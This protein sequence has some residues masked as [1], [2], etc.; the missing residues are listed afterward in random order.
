VSPEYDRQ[1]CQV[2]TIRL[3]ARLEAR[4][5]SS[6]LDLVTSLMSTSVVQSPGQK[7]ETVV[8]RLYS[9]AKQ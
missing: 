7:R 8:E 2:G 5:P 1:R 9:L 3:I 4:K 6:C